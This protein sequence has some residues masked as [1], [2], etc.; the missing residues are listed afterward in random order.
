MNAALQVFMI[1][2][3]KRVSTEGILSGKENLIMSS[4]V[5]SDSDARYFKFA[6]ETNYIDA[7]HNNEHDFIE[8]V[9]VKVD[10]GIDLDTARKQAFSE[11]FA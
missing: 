9:G 8:R 1:A 4:V 3:L 11:V 2:M 10:S 7:N 5:E 6:C